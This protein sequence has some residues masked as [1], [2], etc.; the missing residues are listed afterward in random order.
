MKLLF[1]ILRGILIAAFF[2]TL[3]IIG[4][5]GPITSLWLRLGL[6]LAA[7]ILFYPEIRKI[8]KLKNFFRTATSVG[9]LVVLITAW[10]FAAVKNFYQEIFE[11]YLTKPIPSSVKLIKGDQGRWLDAETFLIFETDLATFQFLSKYYNETPMRQIPER[12]YG[13]K[14][15]VKEEPWQK[16]GIKCFQKIMENTTKPDRNGKTQRYKQEYYL[17][18]DE[19]AGRVYFY[20]PF[21]TY[22]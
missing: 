7:F 20:R 5:F 6:S 13:L 18:W 14:T 8:L 17:L 2:F 19:A 1:T 15:Y 16:A 12:L 22:E 9:V 4:G 11:H 21:T 3:F 10:H